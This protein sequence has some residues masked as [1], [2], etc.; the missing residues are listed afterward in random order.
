VAN[1]VKENADV[2]KSSRR[3]VK[4]NSKYVSTTDS[5][6]NSSKFGTQKSRSAVVDD[7]SDDSSDDSESSIQP[8][9]NV[10]KN[11]S[12]NLVTTKTT[13]SA[14]SKNPVVPRQHDGGDTI[15]SS[16]NVSKHDMSISNDD[17]GDKGL[18]GLN[19]DSEKDEANSSSSDEGTESDTS[20]VT[21]SSV[22]H[23]PQPTGEGSTRNSQVTN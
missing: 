22:T 7:S 23:S 6:S 4:P 21:V 5:T 2:V 19:F 10:K 8:K 11:K 14:T 12:N 18:A 9:G 17:T 1:N 15:V 3:T 13:S 20:E 16:L